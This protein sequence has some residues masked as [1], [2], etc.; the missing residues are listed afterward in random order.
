MTALA[1]GECRPLE[2]AHERFLASGFTATRSLQFSLNGQ[3]KRREVARMSYSA[4]NVD[5]IVVE[6]EV[7]SKNIV[8]EGEGDPL[9]DLEFSCSRLEALGRNRFVLRSEDG[10]E[11]ATFVLEPERRVVRPE[12]WRLAETERFMFKK[13]EIEGAASYEDFGW[14]EGPAIEAEPPT[15][16]DG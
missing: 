1:P 13:F 5:V 8:I 3:L 10:T 15:P 9:I 16:G 11:T 7:L 4:A 2:E 12:S 14:T 6:E